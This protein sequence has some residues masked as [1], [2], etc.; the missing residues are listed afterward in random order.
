MAYFD[1]PMC[2]PAG[3]PDATSRTC[4]PLGAGIYTTTKAYVL[5]DPTLEPGDTLRKETIIK[6]N[7]RRLRIPNQIILAVHTRPS[8]GRLR[9][10]V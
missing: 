3:T 5:G 7:L 4:A 8:R 10:M 6:N 9:S 1:V 2:Y